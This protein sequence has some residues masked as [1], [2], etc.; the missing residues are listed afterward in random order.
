M[1]GAVTLKT[2]RRYR[3]SRPVCM[4][5]MLA[6]SSAACEA[7]SSPPDDAPATVAESDS[8]ADADALR[9]AED[10]LRAFFAVRSQ[11]QDD[12]SVQI[13]AQEP[14]LTARDVHRGGHGAAARRGS[15]RGVL[16]G[17]HRDT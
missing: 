11:A 3:L 7:E 9:A 14:Y 16:L 17:R 13:D 10:T 8:S 1:L 12:P 5:L 6:L 2:A 4:V 15:S